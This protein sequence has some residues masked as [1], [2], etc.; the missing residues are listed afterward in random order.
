VRRVHA[1]P[2]PVSH[3]LVLPYTP[4]LPPWHVVLPQLLRA[5]LHHKQVARTQAKAA[6]GGGRN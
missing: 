1:R 2:W 5:A 4:A 6:E 3:P